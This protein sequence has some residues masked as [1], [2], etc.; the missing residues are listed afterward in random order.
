[1]LHYYYFYAL[2]ESAI[3]LPLP[4]FITKD[5]D[6]GWVDIVPEWQWHDLA[7]HEDL[8]LTEGVVFSHG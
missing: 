2:S 1:M 7:G 8:E 4:V 3:V 5:L 6:G